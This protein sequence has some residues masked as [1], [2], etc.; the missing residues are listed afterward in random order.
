LLLF[1]FAFHVAAV[2]R[3]NFLKAFHSTQQGTKINNKL[4]TANK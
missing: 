1:C 4:Y 2:N 3:Y